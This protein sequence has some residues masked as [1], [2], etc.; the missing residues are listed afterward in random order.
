VQVPA[1]GTVNPDRNPPRVQPRNTFDAMAGY[2]NV[3]HTERYKMNA[4]VSV[5]NLTN[6][7]ALYNFLSTFSGTHFVAPRSLSGQITF[8]F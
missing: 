5:V 2:D 4:N 1:P 8:V 6:K 7:Y 3:F